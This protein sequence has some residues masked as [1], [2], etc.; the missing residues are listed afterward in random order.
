MTIWLVDYLRVFLIS[1]VISWVHTGQLF[2]SLAEII[3]EKYH[4][5]MELSNEVKI[6]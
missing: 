2:V 5:Y 1:R 6:S 3:G 4:V